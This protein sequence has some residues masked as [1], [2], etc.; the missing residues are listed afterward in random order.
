MFREFA[1]NPLYTG[2]YTAPIRIP[3]HCIACT[4]ANSPTR[5]GLSEVLLVALIKINRYSYVDRL[6]LSLRVVGILKEAISIPGAVGPEVRGEYLLSRLHTDL[7][8]NKFWSNQSR[9]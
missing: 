1:S 6:S 2:I 5:L 7:R 9:A 8:I 3:L 4:S